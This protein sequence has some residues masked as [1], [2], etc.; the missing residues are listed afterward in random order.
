VDDKTLHNISASNPKTCSIIRV[1][2]RLHNGNTLITDE[3][4]ELTR[5]V[6]SKGDTVREFKLSEPNLHRSPLNRNRNPNLRFPFPTPRNGVTDSSQGV[7]LTGPVPP[8]DPARKFPRT[9]KR[10]QHGNPQP[11]IVF[12]QTCSASTI[13][14]T[15]WQSMRP[16]I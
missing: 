2:I 15:W 5:E 16:A 1:A 4:D 6:N 10:C 3:R 14:L 12:S 11:A 13:A 7:A 8:L 9:S